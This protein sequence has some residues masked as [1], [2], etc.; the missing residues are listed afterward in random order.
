[1]PVNTVVGIDAVLTVSRVEVR[2]VPAMPVPA[3]SS[4]VPSGARTSEPTTWR[5][6]VAAP[7]R[8]PVKNSDAPVPSPRGTMVAPSFVPD[9]SVA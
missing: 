1:M 7:G 6:M 8:A 2:V 9:A 3:A 5:V 4:I